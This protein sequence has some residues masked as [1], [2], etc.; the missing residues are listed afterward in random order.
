LAYSNNM[1]LQLKKEIEALVEFLVKCILEAN[2]FASLLI[3]QYGNYFCQKLFPRLTNEQKMK[4]WKQLELD[5]PGMRK[6]RLP[7]IPEEY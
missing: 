3:H 2:D 7:M 1:P 4:L 6:D 5:V